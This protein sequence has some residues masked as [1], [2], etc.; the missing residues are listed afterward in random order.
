MADNNMFLDEA[1]TEIVVNQIKAIKHD[2]KFKTGLYGAKWD[3]TTNRLTRTRD[4]IGI[5]S[6]TTNFVHKGTI[7]ANYSNPFDSI[8]PW[9]EMK[10]VNVDLTKYGAGGYTLKQC[11]SAVYG[12]PDF[13]YEGSG[14]IFVGRYVPEFWYTRITDES[15]DEYLISQ[16]ARPGYTHVDEYIRGVSFCTDVGSNRVTSGAGVSLTDIAVSQIHTR[17]KNSGFTLMDIYTLDA[18]IIL[19]LVEF[20]NMN[21]QQALGDGCANCYRQDASNVISTVAVKNGATTF[22]V[23]YSAALFGDMQTGA[24]LSFGTSTGAT[25]YKAII[26]SATNDGTDIS[27]IL[28]RTI[29]ITSGMI[30]S[31]HGFSA[32]EFNLLASSVGNASGY[33]GTNGKANAWYRGALLYGNRYSYILGIY[34]QEGNNHIWLCPRDK[35]L[36]AY[37]AINT[38]D[39]EDTG[40][41]LPALASTGWQT[42]GGNAQNLDGLSAFMITGTSSGSS[43]SPVGDQQYLPTSERVNSVL[44]FGCD[45]S[46]GWYCGVFG[47]AWDRTSGRSNWN[48]AALP[49]LKKSL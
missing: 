31:V 35:N 17:A 27:V 18:E 39:H 11:I 46:F 43:A 32:C 30:M 20:A 49:L 26:V 5:T 8:Y 34:R 14:T 9:S 7:N 10:V 21:A 13:T 28:D 15:G 3:R 22:T 37:D 29:A 45:A 41:A 42:V 24:Q 47:G 25:T 2:L 48:A 33:I 6:D 40:V 44:F 36:D 16:F 23:P 4:A 12:D 38:T 1:G 19:Y